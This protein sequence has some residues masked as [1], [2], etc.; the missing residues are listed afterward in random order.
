MDRGPV[1]PNA[2]QS[3]GRTLGLEHRVGKTAEGSDRPCSARYPECSSNSSPPEST[4]MHRNCFVFAKVASGTARRLVHRVFVGIPLDDP[5]VG[6]YGRP[7]RKQPTQ[8]DMYV[9]CERK[10]AHERNGVLVLIRGI[11]H[12]LIEVHLTSPVVAFARRSASSTSVRRRYRLRQ[13]RLPRYPSQSSKHPSLLAIGLSNILYSEPTV[14]TR[15]PLA[16]RGSER[17]SSLP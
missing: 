8:V 14:A 4:V 17:Q 6:F 9:A 1:A 7:C 3:V 12:E 2:A 15:S 11:V 5:S 13:N 16:S 10:I